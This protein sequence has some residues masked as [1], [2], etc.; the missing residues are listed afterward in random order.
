MQ[1]ILLETIEKLGGIGDVVSVK[2]G[3]A[4][5]FLI[6]F[7]KALRAT[8]ENMAYFEAQKEKLEEKNKKK[9]DEAVAFADKISDL[10]FS[11]I[12]KAQNNGSLYGA[13]SVRE[14]M[15]KAKELGVAIEKSKIF[16]PQNIK[17]VGIHEVTIRLHPE[18][19]C[20]IKIYVARSFDELNAIKSGTTLEEL[21]SAEVANKK[22]ESSLKEET[23]N[24]GEATSNSKNIS[25]ENVKDS[26]SVE[27]SSA[28]KE[29][30]KAD[31]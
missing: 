9:K 2:N 11:I 14:I 6:P 23:V 17:E 4:N 12:A 27:I 5:N 3:F 8:K 18:V 28:E 22:V 29:Q 10:D 13:I 26:Q 30:N 21:E 31:V 16:I 20:D 7:Q 24:E 19:H 15:L 25:N 1:I